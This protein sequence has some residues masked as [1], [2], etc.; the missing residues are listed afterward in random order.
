MAHEVREVMT[1]NPV[2]LKAED[3]LVVAARAMRDKGIGDVLIMKDSQLC[4]IVT[5]R[6]ITVR[7][8]ADGK[9]P[10]KVKLG[11]IC[12]QELVTISADR[13]VSEAISLMR[14]K[15]LRRLPVV[16]GAKPVGIVS[17]GDLALELDER[18]V[19]ASISAAEPNA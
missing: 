10:N 17:I 8:T 9:D 6:D 13:P 7:A 14:N 2:M 5:D 18:S 1:E 3:T 16:E 12:S 19:L 4:G 15:A 11:D